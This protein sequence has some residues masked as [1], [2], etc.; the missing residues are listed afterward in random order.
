MKIKIIS[1]GTTTRVVDAVTGEPMAGVQMVNF[2]SGTDGAPEALL[3]VLGV[4]CEILTEARADLIPDEIVFDIV[5]E[6]MTLKDFVN[7]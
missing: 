3:H 1:D 7:D 6:V 4:E 5:D 2:M